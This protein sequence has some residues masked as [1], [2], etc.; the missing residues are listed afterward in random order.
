MTEKSRAAE[1]FVSGIAMDTWAWLFQTRQLQ[2]FG[3]VAI[4]RMAGVKV[5]YGVGLWLLTFP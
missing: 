4:Y 2:W 3:S 1:I 5:R